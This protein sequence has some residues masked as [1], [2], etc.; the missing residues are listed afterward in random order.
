[1]QGRDREDCIAARGKGRAGGELLLYGYCCIVVIV[2][3]IIIVI[4]VTTVSI[5][6]IIVIAIFVIIVI[7]CRPCKPQVAALRNAFEKQVLHPKSTN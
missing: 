7:T 3:V 1:M 6:V 5:F 4:V 2:Y